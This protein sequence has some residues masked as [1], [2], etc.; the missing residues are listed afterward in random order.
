MD[1]IM[2]LPPI[3][4]KDAILTIM[5]QGCLRATVFLA[6]DTTITGPGI[7]QL[8]LDHIYRWFGLPIKVISDRDPR[9]TSHFGKGLAKKLG[10]QQ[11]L[12]T[13]FHPQT[14]GLLEQKNQWVE[15]YLQLVTSAA[16]KDWTQWLA[17]ASTVHNN[18][19]N[20]TTGL[21]PNQVLLGYNISLNLDLVS[22]VINETAEEH[23]KMMEQRW[24]QATAALNET[25]ERSGTP[26]AQYS[27]GDQ[28]WLEGRN[29]CLPFQATKLAPK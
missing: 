5:D 14:D 19:R 24:A 22:S 18:Q 27:P 25:A 3:R 20:S 9:F 12:S 16:P 6:C 15:Q 4:G 8:Y 11:N 2:G 13:A 26:L 1:L 17:L 23:V 21:S 29:L 28:V 10:I 7:A